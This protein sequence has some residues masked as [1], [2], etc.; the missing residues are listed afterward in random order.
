MVI[1]SPFPRLGDKALA[2]AAA[3]A[4]YAQAC[5]YETSAQLH[6]ADVE[7]WRALHRP[8]SLAMLPSP[9]SVLL[10]MLLVM[11]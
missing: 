10:A 2:E 7:R 1:A 4:G 9:L 11:M 8:R 6:E 5:P 3:A